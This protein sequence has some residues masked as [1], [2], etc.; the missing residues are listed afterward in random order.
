MGDE[1]QKTSDEKSESDAKQPPIEIDVHD[2][3]KKPA[4]K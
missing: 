4:K 3:S 2:E 1:K